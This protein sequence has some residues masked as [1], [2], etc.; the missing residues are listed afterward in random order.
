MIGNKTFKTLF[1][2]L[3]CCVGG[4]TLCAQDKAAIRGAVTDRQTGEPIVYATVRL[5]EL[6]IVTVTGTDGTFSLPE[7]PRGTYHLNITYLG[8]SP[9]NREV[10]A[11]GNVSLDIRMD[12]QSLNLE[13]V[14]VMA[15]N[16]P[17]AGT[18]SSTVTQAALEYIQPSSLSDIFQ[19]L[20]GYLSSDSNISGKEQMSARQAGSDANTAL[21]TA[22]IS[23]GAPMS[24]NATMFRL[25]DEKVSARTTAGGGTDLR[26]IST[27]H[28]EQVEV[29]QGISS[30]KYGDLSSGVVILKPKSGVSPINVRLKADPLNKLFYVGKGFSLGKNAGTL[31]VGLDVTQGRPDV[32]NNLQKYTRIS[33]QANYAKQSRF[34]GSRLANNVNLYYIGTI[35]T[36]KTDPDLTLKTDKYNASFNR[37]MLSYNGVLDVDRKAVSRVELT[38]ST[39]YTANVLR[40]DM[41]V[42]PNG[43]IPYPTAT[44]PGE[45]EGT[46][47]PAEYL[48]HYKNED[49]PFSF[50]A[51]LN[52]MNIFSAGKTTH[53]LMVG[54]ETSY[55]KNLGRGMI[56]DKDLPPYP[57]SSYA[58]RPRP[59]NDVPGM[60]KTSAFAEEKFMASLGRNRMA[61]V[62]GVRLS[63]LHNLPAG[64]QIRGKVYAEPRVNAT[65][66]FPTLNAGSKTP[67]TVA[68][69]AGYGQ[70]MKM[71]TLD[72]LYPDKSYTDVIVL[73]YY[74]Q[75]E[76]NRVLWTNTSVKDRVNPDLKPNKN[77]KYEV[78]GDLSVGPYHFSL[79]AFQEESTSGFDY[80]SRY[81]SFP[82]IKYTT[83]K[84]PVD[85]KP[86]LSDFNTEQAAMLLSYS[87]PVNS[88][89]TVKKGVEYSIQIPEIRA[90]R[91]S[92][93]IN[94]AYFRTLYDNSLPMQKY[95]GGI[96]NGKPYPYVGIYDWD[97]STYREQFNTNFWL[98]THIP[99]FRL[100]FSAM[101]QV[102]WLTQSWS[103]KFSGLPTS[104]MDIDGNVHPFTPNMADDPKFSS[105][106]LSFSDGYFKPNHSPVSVSLN[107]KA[108]K[109]IGKNLKASFFVNRLWDYNP[110]YR[111]NLNTET[112]KWVVPFFG[113]E[114]QIKI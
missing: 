72:Y 83:L 64:Y 13:D 68:L 84:N 97:Y 60:F 73:N 78:G 55:D 12:I 113:A 41:I 79:T 58:S 74:S 40:R 19:L 8:Y 35:D 45:H 102:V 80:E 23:N 42:A 92:M 82:Y 76:A 106:V 77:V 104:Y 95:P 17:S 75:T 59:Y 98:N 44:T 50:F 57:T 39:D 26:Q 81:F 1:T 54:L 109:E 114:M 89:R 36:Q 2:A 38:V 30:V 85:G 96:V 61:I 15:V 22:I 16:K 52:A 21:G 49:M 91:T 14:T 31:H 101:V 66:T 43:V 100:Y 34:L 47:L 62:A 32:R 4:L 33:V 70:Q 53:R 110:R 93:T 37:L 7:I 112:R 18:S 10:K 46:Y 103:K 86:S 56:Y 27:D 69:R 63:M 99:K 65:W 51:Q 5:D 28:V 107:L 105:I 3:W 67:V 29:V 20:P 87:V 90:I 24:N 11:D 88:E 48:S 71:P 9:V 94:G 6:S 111:T 108:S 25:P